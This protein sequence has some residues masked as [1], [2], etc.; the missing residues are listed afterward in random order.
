MRRLACKRC[1]L[2]AVKNKYPQPVSIDYT[3]PFYPDMFECFELIAL[4]LTLQVV[5][6]VCK[7]RTKDCLMWSL[8]RWERVL[9]I[10]TALRLV[11]VMLQWPLIQALGG[12][13]IFLIA[14]W[15]PLL[16]TSFVSM[17]VLINRVAHGTDETI[18]RRVAHDAGQNIVRCR[19]P[20]SWAKGRQESYG[21][22][23]YRDE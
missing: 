2:G 3:M 10:A 11:I 22:R 7:L 4:S 1:F 9:A 12:Q 15:I 19:F 18:K 23:F 14:L 21:I 16:C 13:S 20:P 17:V 6:H 5:L 8:T